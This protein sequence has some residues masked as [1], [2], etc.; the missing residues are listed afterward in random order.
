MNCY[1]AAGWGDRVKMLISNNCCRCHIHQLSPLGKWL[2]QREVEAAQQWVCV[3]MPILPPIRTLGSQE[4]EK[5]CVLSLPL[6]CHWSGFPCKFHLLTS[7]PILPAMYKRQGDRA[8]DLRDY[9]QGQGQ[10]RYYDDESQFFQAETD[11]YISMAQLENGLSAIEVA[12]GHVRALSELVAG[13]E[14]ELQQ[15]MDQVDEALATIQRHEDHQK[16]W[17]APFYPL[18]LEQWKQIKHSIGEGGDGSSLRLKVF[19]LI[20]TCSLSRTI[21]TRMLLAYSFPTI[22]VN[23]LGTRWYQSAEDVDDAKRAINYK[24]RTLMACSDVKEKIDQMLKSFKGDEDERFEQIADVFNNPRTDELYVGGHSKDTVRRMYMK[25]LRPN[26][27][28][29]YQELQNLMIFICSYCWKACWRLTRQGMYQETASQT[30]AS[31]TTASQTTASLTGIL[32]PELLKKCVSARWQAQ[33]CREF[34]RCVDTFGQSAVR[35]LVQSQ[36]DGNIASIHEWKTP[37]FTN[38]LPKPLVAI[39]LGELKDDIMVENVIRASKTCH[40]FSIMVSVTLGQT[41]RTAVVDSLARL[42]EISDLMKFRVFVVTRD[43]EEEEEASRSTRVLELGR[44][45][46]RRSV[47]AR[48]WVQ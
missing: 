27:A 47:G 46:A 44:A 26:L 13:Q 32:T 6:P 45:L 24:E 12:A 9:L 43:E 1:A 37:A 35:E 25:L 11:A 40:F 21:D 4:V 22:I 41:R 5:L 42:V 10:R 34:S 28:W 23:N 38:E 18:L 17:S 31:Q 2:A 30:T 3:D 16:I 29:G 8:R 48:V 14:G 19:S 33:V 39:N 7:S 15:Q 20:S 36:T